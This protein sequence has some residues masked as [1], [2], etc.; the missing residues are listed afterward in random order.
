MLKLFLPVMETEMVTAWRADLSKFRD[1]IL[2][3][4]LI[5]TLFQSYHQQKKKWRYLVFKSYLAM[6]IFFSYKPLQMFSD[7]KIPKFG[8]LGQSLELQFSRYT[9]S[10]NKT[11]ISYHP[12]GWSSRIWTGT[13]LTDKRGKDNLFSSIWKLYLK[14]EFTHTSHWKQPFLFHCQCCCIL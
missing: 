10:R 12:Q 5:K 2:F 9:G 1:T 8:T 13:W 7:E 14:E 11:N 6:S 3:K 4:I